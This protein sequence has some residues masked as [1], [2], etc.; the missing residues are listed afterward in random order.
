[1]FI[2]TITSD[3]LVD[4]STDEQQL[5]AGGKG[6]KTCPCVDSEDTSP[7]PPVD[8]AGG[9]SS[10]LCYRITATPFFQ[11]GNGAEPDD[12]MEE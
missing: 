9:L 12:D 3:L 5:L 2:P 1:M 10:I 11:C 4:L 7:T 6:K 8:Q